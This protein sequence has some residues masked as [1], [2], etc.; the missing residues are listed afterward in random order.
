MFKFSQTVKGENT[1]T[2]AH[3]PST[4]DTVN[5]HVVNRKF[6]HLLLKLS[7]SIYCVL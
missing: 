4:V 1:L 5:L 6:E 2:A 7:S 3:R